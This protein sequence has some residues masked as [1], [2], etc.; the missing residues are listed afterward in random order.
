MIA[1]RAARPRLLLHH[2]L[3]RKTPV[4]MRFPPPSL[5]RRGLVPLQLAAREEALLL[6]HYGNPSLRDA[7]LRNEQLQVAKWEGALYIFFLGGDTAG[8]IR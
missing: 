5:L 7:L 8:D 4:A 1:R 2:F 6:V 3:S